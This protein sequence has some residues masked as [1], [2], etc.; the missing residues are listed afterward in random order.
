MQE[1]EY[2]VRRN[3]HVFEYINTENGRGT[4]HR[5]T[6][7]T[8]LLFVKQGPL[9]VEHEQQKYTLN[10]GD[11]FVVNTGESH[12]TEG[13]IGT[14][15]HITLLGNGVIS[16]FY[17]V[18]VVIHNYI[19]AES[20]KEKGIHSVLTESFKMISEIKKN[21]FGQAYNGNDIY[22]K[23]IIKLEILKIYSLLM[24]YYTNTSAGDPLFLSDTSEALEDFIKNNLEKNISIKDIA[25][26]LNYSESYTGKFVKRILGD[27]FKNTLTRHRIDKACEL[28]YDTDYSIEFISEQCGFNTS[29]AFFKQFAKIVGMSPTKYRKSRFNTQK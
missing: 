24:K 26:M 13:F 28:L 6:D 29:R 20:Q 15:Q 10:A 8:E 16:D 27:T 1:N 3:C 5:H 12:C 9:I 23:T 4:P 21:K 2:S 7:I 18:P 11:I 17:K 25:K 19:S 22:D 14:H